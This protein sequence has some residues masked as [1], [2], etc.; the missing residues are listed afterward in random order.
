MP[1]CDCEWLECGQRISRRARSK[2]MRRTGEP[3][4][5][6]ADCRLFAYA[7]EGNANAAGPSFFF[8]R[9]AVL[10][11]FFIC[12]WVTGK[13]SE[14][15]WT[16]CRTPE[17]HWNRRASTR[18]MCTSRE[19]HR[20]HENHCDHDPTNVHHLKKINGLNPDELAT[21]SCPRCVG[22]ATK[23][24]KILCVHGFRSKRGFRISQSWL[25]SFDAATALHQK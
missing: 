24:S 17:C 23:V 7:A 25:S 6:G 3:P 10:Q 9:L 5:D 21:H 4:P 15:T 13:A 20:T 8:L 19:T 14:V 18:C 11:V 22:P 1:L 16:N 2:T 12:L